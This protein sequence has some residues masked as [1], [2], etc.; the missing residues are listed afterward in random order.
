[1]KILVTGSRRW[2]WP[3]VVRDALDA[4]VGGLPA[5]QVTILHGANPGG[6][7]AH[8][9]TYA[10]EQGWEVR[11]FPGRDRAS[12][13]ARNRAMIG[14][15]PDVVLAFVTEDS[16]GTWHTITLAQEAGLLVRAFGEPATEPDVRVCRDAAY[17][18]T[19]GGG[20]ANPTRRALALTLSA[21]ETG[22]PIPPGL[23]D[24]AMQ[25]TRTES[26]Q[27]DREGPRS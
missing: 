13:L 11:R 7:D 19:G 1:M 24:A 18:L 22:K 4:A 21:V 16:R 20:W 10:Q 27:P 15:N 3:D 25:I 23:L 26:A 17:R 8:A 12:L 2:P 5:D 14:N 6:A 9:D